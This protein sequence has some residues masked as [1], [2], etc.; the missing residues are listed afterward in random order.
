MCLNNGL[1]GEAL[2]PIELSAKLSM[3]NGHVTVTWQLIRRKN[4]AFQ[5]KQFII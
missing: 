2:D 5:P 4:S 1:N 3:A